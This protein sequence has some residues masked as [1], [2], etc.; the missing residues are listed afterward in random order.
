L[1][2]TI[3]ATCARYVTDPGSAASRGRNRKVETWF[4]ILQSRSLSGAS[5][6]AVEQLQEHIDAFIAAYN[7]TAE[8]FVWEGG[9]RRST[10]G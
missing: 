8:R 5:F 2:A 4:S 9:A 3:T 10:W 6:K 1:F 7:E